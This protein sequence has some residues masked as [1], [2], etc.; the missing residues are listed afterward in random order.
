MRNGHELLGNEKRQFGKC[1]SIFK[2]ESS[3]PFVCRIFT[4]KDNHVLLKVYEFHGMLLW[5]AH[6]SYSEMRSVCLGNVKVF[7]KVRAVCLLSVEVLLWKIITFL[8]KWFNFMKCFF[9]K[10]TCVSQKSYAVVWDMEK[11]VKSENCLPY[12]CRSFTLKIITFFWKYMN[13]MECFCEKRTWV[14]LTWEVSVWEM[15]KYFKKWE[16]CAFSL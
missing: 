13:F 1:Q 11:L 3:V 2:S 12:L 16:Q 15:S 5:E 8:W 7:L 10:C 6:M 9:E 4:L 14:T